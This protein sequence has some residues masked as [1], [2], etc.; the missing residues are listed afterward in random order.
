MIFG[1]RD[2]IGISIQSD[3]DFFSKF[4]LPITITLNNHLEFLPSKSSL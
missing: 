1:D 4:P 3:R 2:L